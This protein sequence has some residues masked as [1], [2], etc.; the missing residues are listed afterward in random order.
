MTQT[1][2][3]FQGNEIPKPQTVRFVCAK[4]PELKMWI[5][6]DHFGWV[7]DEAGRQVQTT[8]AGKMVQFNRGVLETEDMDVIE[9]I[10]SSHL[11]NGVGRKAIHESAPID[12]A[13][14]IL[15]EHIRKVGATQVLQGIQQQ[16]GQYAT[17]PTQIPTQDPLGVTS[18][19]AQNLKG[20]IYATPQQK[21]VVGG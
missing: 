5:K 20:Q 12:P 18:Q 4:Y 11:F 8:I 21:A 9:K 10:R 19:Y 17:A 2:P 1:Q 7:I 16:Y 6:P 15:F 3:Q 13:T 14:T